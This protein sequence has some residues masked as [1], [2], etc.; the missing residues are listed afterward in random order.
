MLAHVAKLVAVEA[1]HQVQNKATFTFRQLTMISFSSSG[2]LKVRNRVLVVT[3]SVSLFTVTLWTSTTPCSCSSVFISISVTP[4]N[5]RQQMV[6]HDEFSALWM[7]THVG[8]STNQVV[9]RR[10]IT[11]DFQVHSTRNDPSLNLLMLLRVPA[12]AWNHFWTAKGNSLLSGKLS[13]DDSTTRNSGQ[14]LLVLQKCLLSATVSESWSLSCN[15]FVLFEGATLF[16]NDSLCFV[17]TCHQVKQGDEHK[18]KLQQ[19]RTRAQNIIYSGDKITNF[20]SI[21]GLTLSH[22]LQIEIRAKHDQPTDWVR[23][24]HLSRRSLGQRSMLDPT[25]DLSHQDPIFPPTRYAAHSKCAGSESD[26]R[27]QELYKE[28]LCCR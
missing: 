28:A 16:I 6:P 17:R 10:P 26:C 9:L 22:C 24:N 18:Q 21:S 8:L 13:L 23:P 1:S 4:D 5:S 3:F 2:V 25:G 15:F 27:E 14:L 12:T 20:N 7:E 11:C 19:V